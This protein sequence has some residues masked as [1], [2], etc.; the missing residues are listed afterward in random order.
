[1]DVAT[2]APAARKGEPRRTMKTQCF[3]LDLQNDPDLIAQYEWYHRRENIWPE[4]YEA[5][6]GNGIE[7]MEIYRAGDRLVM[8]LQTA[9]DFSMEMKAEIDRGTPILQKWEELMWTY[10]KALPFAQPGQ[11]WVPAAKIFETQ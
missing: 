3:I 6:H 4:V 11:K 2:H 7:S 1:M 10:Q 8:I 9:D 5:A